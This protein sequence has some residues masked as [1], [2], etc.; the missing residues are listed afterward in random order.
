MYSVRQ[1]PETRTTREVDLV[2]R[3]LPGERGEVRED[4]KRV[5]K[6]GTS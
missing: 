5:F 4:E 2:K 3:G 6:G 1:R